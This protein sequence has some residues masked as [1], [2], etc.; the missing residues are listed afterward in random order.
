MNCESRVIILSIVVQRCC[1][2]WTSWRHSGWRTNDRR[3]A[4]SRSPSAF[5]PQSAT[6][7]TRCWLPIRSSTTWRTGELLEPALGPHILLPTRVCVTIR[8]RLLVPQTYFRVVG[9][10]QCKAFFATLS[11][12]DS[13][14]YYWRPLRSAIPSWPQSTQWKHARLQYEIMTRM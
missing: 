13:S 9:L 12:P 5:F 10:N 6:R 1:T 2:K 11:F 4:S 7:K 8:S 14:A 3:T